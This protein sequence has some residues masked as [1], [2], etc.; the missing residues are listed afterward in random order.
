MTRCVKIMKIIISSFNR[1]QFFFMVF[2]F[3]F[4]RTKCWQ[5]LCFPVLLF[6]IRCKVS[7]TGKNQFKNKYKNIHTR[8]S[9]QMNQ[10][11]IIYFIKLCDNNIIEFLRQFHAIRIY[12]FV[13]W[14][15]EPKVPKYYHYIYYR[16]Y[17]MIRYIYI[18]ILYNMFNN[19]LLLANGIIVI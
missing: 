18:I 7:K 16:Y 3:S 15:K 5:N 4:L 14:K 19:F 9:N 13:L 1:S 11:Y 12:F 17:H 10:L 2:V 8:V 6:V